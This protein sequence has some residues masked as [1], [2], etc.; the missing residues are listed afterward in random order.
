MEYAP[1]VNEPLSD[2]TVPSRRAA[3][4]RTLA[5]VDAGLG[6]SWSRP[7]LI[8]GEAV[9][10]GAWQESFDPT[11]PSRVV[12]RVATGTTELADLAV[13]AAAR[14]FETWSRVPV[15]ERAA[16]VGRVAAILRDRRDEFAATMVVEAGKTWGEA[17]AD[18][19]EAV[20]FCEYYIRD[21]IRLAGPQPIT[22]MAGTRNRF[23]YSPIGI[24][25]VIPPWNFP[26][27]I[28]VGMTMSAVVTGNV[29]IVKPSSLTPV[30]AARFIDACVEAGIPDGVVNF[31]PG[32][33]NLVGMHLVDHPGVRFVS[34]TGSREVG[35][36]IYSRAAVV[37][38]GQ[39]WLKRVVA[40][41][42]GKNAIL[43]DETADLDAAARAIAASAFGFGG[44][45][46]SACSRVVA[47]DAIH[48]DLVGRVVAA[49]RDIRIGDPRDPDTNLGPLASA[50]QRRTA[51]RYVAIGRA[52][53]EVVL[54]PDTPVPATG[55]YVA[56]HVVA[57]VASRSRL[58]QEEVF[59]PV[60]AVM[61]ARDFDDGLRIANDTDFGLTGAVFSRDRDRL[62][63]AAD[64]FAC[65]NL[66]FNRKCTGAFVG[67]E[68]FGGFNMSGT[69]SKAGGHDHLLLFLQG[70]S[71][72]EPA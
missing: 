6:P 55:H 26:L 24:G 14:A 68:P 71:I 69:D 70:K 56:P 10:T 41:M 31:L 33:G 53:G 59:G 60:L 46:C 11:S 21:A 5:A 28:T 23:A 29:A 49:A 61:R 30:I 36:R 47:V 43:V 54:G 72:S 4:A 48:D 64:E 16:A 3:F 15:A 50:D 39:R 42:G 32:P 20:D 12:G 18:A 62:D 45:K 44:Q 63:R 35:E 25:V 65:G 51:E 7:M 22:R 67:V 57:G 52:E 40:E 19:A 17:D 2:F 8:G 9:E 37:H 58:G 1:F 38:P 66:Y 27:A 34:F 13:A